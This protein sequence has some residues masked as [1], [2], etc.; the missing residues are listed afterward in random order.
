MMDEAFICRLFEI[1]TQGAAIRVMGTEAYA[2]AIIDRERMIPEL[3]NSL[4]FAQ[5]IRVPKRW[6]KRGGHL[7]I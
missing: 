2:A 6:P 1:I 7:R 4:T 5:E 3:R